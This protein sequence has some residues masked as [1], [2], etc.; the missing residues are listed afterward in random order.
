MILEQN[1]ISSDNYK[2]VIGVRNSQ[3]EFRLFGNL[4]QII[5]NVFPA[6]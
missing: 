6:S 1:A 5:K 2:D 3:R 4:I